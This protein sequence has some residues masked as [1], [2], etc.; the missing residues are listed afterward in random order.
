MIITGNCI[1]R[2]LKRPKRRGDI[3]SCKCVRYLYFIYGS[4]TVAYLPANILVCRF[5]HSCNLENLHYVDL[6]I[7]DRIQNVVS[8]LKTVL[9]NMNILLE[10]MPN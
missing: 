3:F 6:R 10:R 4:N 5:I 8:D 1:F 2:W 9:S 7:E